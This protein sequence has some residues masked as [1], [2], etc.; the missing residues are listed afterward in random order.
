MEKVR[1][2]NVENT[3]KLTG[4]TVAWSKLLWS[5]RWGYASVVVRSPSGAVMVSAL[6][7]VS[8]VSTLYR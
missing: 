4:I 2:S 3:Q 6:H 8:P 1:G 5:R 7:L